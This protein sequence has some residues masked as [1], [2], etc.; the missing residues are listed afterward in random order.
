M[1]LRCDLVVLGIMLQCYEGI[2]DVLV[3]M[4]KCGD[5]GGVGTN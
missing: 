3:L 4:S 2:R 1:H 5:D